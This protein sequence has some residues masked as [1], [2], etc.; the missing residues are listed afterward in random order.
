MRHDLTAGLLRL[1][2][3]TEILCAYL[4]FCE[5]GTESLGFMKGEHFLIS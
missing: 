4:I 2:C 1:N 5:Y 3:L